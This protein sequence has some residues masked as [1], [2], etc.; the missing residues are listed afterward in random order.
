[1][2]C[3]LTIFPMFEH[4]NSIHTDFINSIIP[5]CFSIYAM[6]LILTFLELDDI[7][8]YYHLVNYSHI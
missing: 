1:M 6:P 4:Y 2:I 8:F 3:G 5:S 7:E